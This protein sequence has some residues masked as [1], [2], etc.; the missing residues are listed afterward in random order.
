LPPS[1]KIALLLAVCLLVYSGVSSAEEPTAR[2]ERLAFEGV[3]QIDEDELADA[4]LTRGP[5]WKP[6][7]DDPV[8]DEASL[9]EDLERVEGFYRAR[10]YYSTRAAA[11]VDWNE[12]RDAVRIRIRVDEGASDSRSARSSA[13]ATIAPR[14]RACS[15]ASRRSA[16]PP[17]RS[18]V[19]PTSIRSGARRRCAGSWIPGRVSASVRCASR[20]SIGS[21]KRW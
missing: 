21:R 20:G 13:Y 15:R 5:S 10:G 16:I 19:A 1:K 17:P 7:V 6:W 8:F 18:R 3:S 12:A 4:L 2:V 9:D 14:A 11:E